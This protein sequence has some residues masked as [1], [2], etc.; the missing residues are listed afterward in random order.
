MISFFQQFL[1]LPFI[2]LFYLGFFPLLSGTLGSLVTLLVF[3]YWHYTA[4]QISFIIVFLQWILITV[5]AIPACNYAEK[6]IFLTKDS[7]KIIIDEYSGMV[8]SLLPLLYFPWQNKFHLYYI[9]TFLLFRFFDITKVLGI[10][11]LEKFKGGLGVMLDDLLAGLYAMLIL[12]SLLY[13]F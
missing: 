5:I 3:W 11:H 8:L 6:K 7:S 10:N 1:I 12:M 4:Q 9:I 13:F 2:S